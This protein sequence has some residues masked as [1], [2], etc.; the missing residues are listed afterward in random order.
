MSLFKKPDA[1]AGITFMIRGEPGSG[2]TRFALGAKRVTKLP[3]AYIG[4]D[5]GAMFYQNDPALGGFLQVETRE[6]KEISAA[7]A[8][9][10]EDWGRSFGAVIVDTVTDMWSAEQRDFEKVAKDGKVQIPMRAWRPLRGGHEQ[11]LRD[12][13]ALPMHTFLICEE[14]PIF[15]KRQQGEEVEIIEVGS[16]EDSDKKD[17]YVCDVRLRLFIQDGGFYAEVLKDRTGTFPMGEIVENPAVEMWIKAAV[18]AAPRPPQVASPAAVED[19]K[20]A[21]AAMEAVKAAATPH[22]SDGLIAKGAG[23]STPAEK[24]PEP[25]AL[26]DAGASVEEVFTKAAREFIGFIGDIK[27]ATH[28][29]NWSKKHGSELRTVIAGLPEGELR[30]ELRAVANEKHNAFDKPSAA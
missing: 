22:V 28:W 29:R 16:R 30:D 12:L 10:R 18:K 25:R 11:K 19:A 21:L 9:L 8:E 24:F 5:R 20:K 14:K 1:P 17:S 13:Q 4:T 2:K 7:I 23:K 3:C 6:A 27:S 15:E 26:P